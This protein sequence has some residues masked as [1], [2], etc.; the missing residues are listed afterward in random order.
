M[1]LP[2]D[3]PDPGEPVR[4]AQRLHDDQVPVA[5]QQRERGGFFRAG[6]E[7]DIGFVDDEEAAEGCSVS[8]RSGG[9]G[10]ET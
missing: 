6:T 9:L 4:L 3:A 5:R 2:G 10:L 7:V 1:W 8:S